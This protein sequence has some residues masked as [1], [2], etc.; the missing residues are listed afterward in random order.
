M[1]DSFGAFILESKLKQD[2]LSRDDVHVIIVPHQ[3]ELNV[4]ALRALLEKEK[5][6]FTKEVTTL[7]VESNLGFPGSSICAVEYIQEAIDQFEP[8]ILVGIGGVLS[9]L[10]G[11]M[12]FFPQAN[13]Q[14]KASSIEI[15]DFIDRKKENGVSKLD[16]QRF[17]SR[18]ETIFTTK[19]HKMNQLMP[20]FHQYESQTI[21]TLSDSDKLT[22]PE[23]DKVN[24]KLTLDDFEQRSVAGFLRLEPD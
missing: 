2:A 15:S 19:E 23:S 14:M 3:D 22:V 6:K 8:K 20:C 4:E 17:L 21:Q 7:Y 18:V 5:L 13:L 12:R 1:H 11:M 16:I 10:W 9:S 24:K